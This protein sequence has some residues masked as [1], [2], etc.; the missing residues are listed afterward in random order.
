MGI[1]ILSTELAMKVTKDCSHVSTIYYKPEIQNCPACESRLRRSHRVWDK[2]IHQL[3]G[4]VRAVSMGYRCPN[5]SCGDT[6]IYRSA[7]AES[8]S[9]K[10]HSFGIDVICEIGRLRFS[11]KMTV[12]EIHRSLRQMISISL[13]NIEYLIETYMLLVAGLK[14]SSDYLSDS[15]GESPL[16][17]LL[18][19]ARDS[20]PSSRSSLLQ[21]FHRLGQVEMLMTALMEMNQVL[22]SACTTI[23]DG[24][25]MMRLQ[26]FSIKQVLITYG[27]SLV[28][29]FSHES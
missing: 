26:V 20:F 9:L 11:E 23:T 6:V 7:F 3:T 24:D 17:C 2:Y 27:I 4:T 28:L 29:I 19:T 10:Y 21:P 12:D 14:Q 25:F 13:R 16:P 1:N 18:R 22:R 8:L 15:A 5:A